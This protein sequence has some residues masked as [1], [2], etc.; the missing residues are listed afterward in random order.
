MNKKRRKLYHFE[1]MILTDK[2][3]FF[4]CYQV[5]Y[6]GKTAWLYMLSD[7]LTDDQKKKLS[8]Y[9]NVIISEC[10]CKYAPEIKHD[11]LIILK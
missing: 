10:H 3:N 9:D 5:K 7:K 8:K 2:I 4:D 1:D 11:N 6:Y